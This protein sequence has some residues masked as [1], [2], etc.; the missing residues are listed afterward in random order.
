[1]ASAVYIAYSIRVKFAFDEV[2]I[3]YVFWG[4]IQENHKIQQES[5][6]SGHK[7]VNAANSQNPSPSDLL[8]T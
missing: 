4:L 3:N 8:V 1:M 2:E 6:S 5:Y 7:R